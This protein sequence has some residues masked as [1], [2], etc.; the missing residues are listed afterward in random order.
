MKNYD[1]SNRVNAMANE[2]KKKDKEKGIFD[3]HKANDESVQYLISHEDHVDDILDKYK[4]KKVSKDVLDQ[5]ADELH[6]SALDHLIKNYLKIEGPMDKEKVQMLAHQYLPTKEQIKKHFKTYKTV[7]KS[8]RD[9]YLGMHSDH[10]GEQLN[11]PIIA[12]FHE[13]DD[14]AKG[15]DLTKELFKKT[16]YSDEEVEHRLKEVKTMQDVTRLFAGA[17]SEVQKNLKRKYLTV[18]EEKEEKKYKKAA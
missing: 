14:I 5:I 11:Q 6:E 12:K 8:A 3:F 13:L 4:R 10:I 1:L 16:G 15:K 18:G 2:K 9:S 7:N 17:Y